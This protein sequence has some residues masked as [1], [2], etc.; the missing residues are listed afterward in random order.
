MNA[1]GQT[2]LGFGC[3]HLPGK[4]A[5]RDALAVL[6]TAFEAGIRHFDVAR[7]YG[8]G[9]A[10]SIVGAFA[11][12]RRAALSLVTKVGIAPASRGIA[13][14][15]LRHALH[16]APTLAKFTPTAVRDALAPR[17]GQFA[18][19]QI[20]QSVEKSLRELRTDY[21][22]ALLLH[23]CA[24]HHI[25]DELKRALE[26][27]KADGKIKRWGI[28]SPAEPTRALI[29]SQP[30]LCGIVQVAAAAD[31]RPPPGAALIVHSVLGKRLAALAERLAGDGA[32]AARFQADVGA[33]P[34]DRSAL[35]EMLMRWELQRRPEAIVLFS[36]TTPAQ[37]R[38][39]AALLSSTRGAPAGLASFM[40]SSA[41]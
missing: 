11:R 6:E 15:A 34:R 40:Q 19:V 17:F 14:R 7:M 4:L 26:R 31:V 2:R 21:V 24:P 18:P 32:L 33:D 37:I 8:D 5:R 30:D 27:L 9:Q 36:S 28:A 3:A 23:E 39:N 12:G 22:D 35:A 16:A 13:A 25:T 29:A 20:R 10:E 41:T 38:Q 1:F